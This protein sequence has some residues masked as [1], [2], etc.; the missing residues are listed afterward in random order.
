MDSKQVERKNFVVA[1]L[2]LK[3]EELKQLPDQM[4]HSLTVQLPNNFRSSKKKKFIKFNGCAFQYYVNGM[5]Q[6]VDNVL[7]HSN[8]ANTSDTIGITNN[9]SYSCFK[10]NQNKCT[11][12]NC[13]NEGNCD[14]CKL[15]LK[16]G[17][18]NK[19]RDY[20]DNT[21][22]NVHKEIYK[23]V[24][25]CFNGCTNCFYNDLTGISNN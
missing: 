24:Q 12:I 1:N 17:N 4:I 23:I 11:C 3:Y 8:M 21:G 19:C 14:S 6:T 13:K 15:S 10:Q 18:C 9:T 25:S 2:N 5:I 22:C 16:C 20:T 7:I